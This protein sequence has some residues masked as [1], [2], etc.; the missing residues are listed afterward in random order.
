MYLMSNT[1]RHWRNF[2]WE[3]TV[4]MSL[5][6]AYRSG[7]GTAPVLAVSRW[8]DLLGGLLPP[9]PPAEKTTARSSATFENQGG[10]ITPKSEDQPQAKQIAHAPQQ[11]VWSAD[12]DRETVAITRNA[13]R[14]LPDARRNVTG[15]T[16]G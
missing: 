14:P 6:A 16:E 11:A 12:K 7:L 10:G 15:R 5:I 9:S 2:Y 13:E 1:E 8:I 4:R 3:K